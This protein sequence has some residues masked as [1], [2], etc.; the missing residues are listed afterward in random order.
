MADRK[1]MSFTTGEFAKLC[2]TTKETLRHYDSMGLLQPEKRGENGYG[3]YMAWQFFDYD[4]ISTLKEAGCSLKEIKD[5]LQGHETE[6]FIR[7]LQEK[8]RQLEREKE[9]LERMQRFLRRTVEVTEN[10]LH[11][12]YG[13]PQLQHCGEEYLIAHAIPEGGDATL[14]DAIGRMR[15]HQEYLNQRQLGEEYQMGSI[16]L[17]ENLEQGLHFDSFYYTKVYEWMDNE[18]LQIKPEGDYVVMLHKGSFVEMN[19]AYNQMFDYI[20]EQGL[21][22]CGNGYEY[23]MVDG[24]A[25]GNM[26]GFITQ[27]SI[28][29]SATERGVQKN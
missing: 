3:Y 7:F 25:A 28:Q 4:M 8:D 18:R 24:L 11:A 26:D 29:V 21:T 27:I 19:A 23:N 9:K 1:K 15:E 6:D 14:V 17:K 16:I 13:Q 10:A 5:Y 12:V 20:K 2:G 22:I